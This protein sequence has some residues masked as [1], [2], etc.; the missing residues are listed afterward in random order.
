MRKN[1]KVTLFLSLLLMLGCN[2]GAKKNQVIHTSDVYEDFP[3]SEKLNFELF[4][5]FDIAADVSPCYIDDSVLWFFDYSDP[6]TLG[7]CYDMNTGKKLSTIGGIGRAGYEFTQF[8]HSII[9]SNNTVQF[10]TQRKDLKVFSKKDIVENVPMGERKYSVDYFPDSLAIS[11]VLKLENGDIL[12][13]IE[14]NPAPDQNTLYAQC[15]LNN[16][17]ILILNDKE[18]NSYDLINYES[19]ENG[20][21]ETPESGEWFGTK[22]K[23]KYSLCNGF[24]M[25]RDNDLAVFT[26][27]N[28]FAFN[29]F[30]IKNK[31][32]LKER[33]Y[34]DI[35]ESK[36]RN[37]GTSNDLGLSIEYGVS[38]DKYIMF[39]VSGYFSKEDKINKIRKQAIFSFDW[40]LHP[41]KRYDLPKV[42]PMNSIFIVANDASAIYLF[43][44]KETELVL[45][46]ALL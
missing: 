42:N 13:S 17:D 10:Y 39:F 27:F 38:N 11:M 41:V 30:D 1:L 43:E 20:N 34:T 3:K 25:A 8:P 44:Y 28:Q 40:D 5:K 29:T 45:H 35:K 4:N 18:A 37:C 6:N 15:K 12:A 23:I 16:R 33:R 31:K 22:D 36:D 7:S 24:I 2:S 19:F 21:E 9:I 26:L 46:K 32:A 14:P